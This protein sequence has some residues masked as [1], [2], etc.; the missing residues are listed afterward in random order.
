[1]ISRF[2]LYIFLKNPQRIGHFDVLL[3]IILELKKNDSNVFLEVVYFDSEQY[4]ILKK[5]RFT[6]EMID[7]VGTVKLL[8]SP[9]N[10]GSIIRKFFLCLKLIPYIF[11]ILTK[12]YVIFLQ[13]KKINHPIDKI[14]SKVVSIRGKT[15]TYQPMNN[16]YLEEMRRH[17]DEYGSPRIEYVDNRET[18]NT[19]NL[20]QRQFIKKIDVG[21]SA[22][23]N[24][25][26]S[27]NYFAMM[28]LSNFSIIGYTHLYPEYVNY[29]KKNYRSYLHSEVKVKNLDNQ[30]IY[31]IFVN[32]YWG[33][34][35]GRDDNWFI[36]KF[37]EIVDCL[38]KVE[39]D[40]L[41][42]VRAHPTMKAD[43]IQQAIERANYDKIYE[44]F[45]HPTLIGIASKAVIGISESTAYHYVM[46]AGTP[47][48][49]YGGMREENYHIFPEGSLNAS[50]G[51]IVA[52]DQY[53]LNEKLQ[54][55]AL[56]N[57]ALKNYQSF[58]KHRMNLS[59]FK[60]N[61]R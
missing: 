40:S 46:G 49:D 2:K 12:N 15:L 52:I 7:K 8:K 51:T 21:D 41:I 28:G 42:I 5:N 17:F 48:F 24:S 43:I 11:K 47:Y 36:K 37:C 34:W 23:I 26:D 53:E 39:N 29:T 20:R 3:P 33:R 14:I 16:H 32:K 58:L 38:R 22:L 4:E 9:G 25:I 30:K 10:K 57:Q 1:M 59:I 50:Y 45:L 60:Q 35:G 6:Y 31:G 56:L 19:I 61:K 55:K 18:Q 27:L 54:N 13:W 44:T